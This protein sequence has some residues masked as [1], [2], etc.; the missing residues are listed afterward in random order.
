MFHKCKT[1]DQPETGREALADFGILSRDFT[2]RYNILNLWYG[3]GGT[4]YPFYEDAK[5]KIEVKPDDSLFTKSWHRLKYHKSY[6]PIPMEVNYVGLMGRY[7]TLR[8]QYI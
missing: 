3:G 8:Q 4:T 6:S 2:R 5:V 7:I 1:K